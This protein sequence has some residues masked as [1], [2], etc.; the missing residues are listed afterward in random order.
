LEVTKLNQ[1]WIAQTRGNVQAE[2][3]GVIPH[4]PHL[5]HAGGGTLGIR[6]SVFEAVGGFDEEFSR[7]QDTDLCMRVQLAGTQLQFVPEA[8]VH[9][10]ARDTLRATFRQAATWGE[11]CV[12]LYKKALGLGVPPVK[13]PWRNGIAHWVGLVRLMAGARNRGD[14]GRFLHSLGF[15]WGMVRGSIKHRLVAF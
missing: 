9:L 4:I 2:R 15:R 11:T 8:E 6:R 3:L 1:P 10:R 7:L 12:V 14:L 5:L 13:R